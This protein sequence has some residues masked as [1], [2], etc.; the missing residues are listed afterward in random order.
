MKYN[1]KLRSTELSFERKVAMLLDSQVDKYSTATFNA[2]SAFLTNLLI[3]DDVEKYDNKNS[4][5]YKILLVLQRH[6]YIA[7]RFTEGGYVNGRY[8]GSKVHVSALDKFATQFGFDDLTEDL[9][10][11]IPV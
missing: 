2:V 5:L 7:M 10:N 3:Y 8:V 1:K 11:Y 9:C 6:G 4:P